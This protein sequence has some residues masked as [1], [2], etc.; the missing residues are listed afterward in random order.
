MQF[1]SKR[2]YIGT[3]E[4]EEA[5]ARAHDQKAIEVKGQE[6]ALSDGLNFPEDATGTAGGGGRGSR[7]IQSFG[8]DSSFC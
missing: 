6:R 2:H 4:D 3:F 8:Y 7:S 1:K 5:A